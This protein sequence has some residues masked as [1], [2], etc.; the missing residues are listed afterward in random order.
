MLDD[1]FCFSVFSE[2]SEKVATRQNKSNIENGHQGYIFGDFKLAVAIK[3]DEAAGE[4]QQ[5]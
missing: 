4:V 1:S 2:S 5:C 3:A